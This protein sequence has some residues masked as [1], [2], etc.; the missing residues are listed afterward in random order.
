MFLFKISL[1]FCTYGVLEATVIILC[2][3][4]GLCCSIYG[5]L[6]S[7][8]SSLDYIGPNGK[9]MVNNGVERLE[10]SDTDTFPE[11]SLD[12]LRKIITNLHNS[13]FKLGTS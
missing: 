13:W 11:F 5:V 12:G 4:T 7:A 8:V 3:H 9:M 1:N 6:H 2:V 10:G